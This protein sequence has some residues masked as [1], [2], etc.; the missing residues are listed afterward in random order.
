LWIAAMGCWLL[1]HADAA[2]TREQVPTTIFVERLSAVLFVLINAASTWLSHK[3]AWGF[4]VLKKALYL[5][6]L[7][8]VLV[9]LFYVAT[10]VG[11][12]FL[13]GHLPTVLLLVSIACVLLFRQTTARPHNGVSA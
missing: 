5:M 6:G 9:V 4:A 8:G 7:R 12:I 2:I 11:K 13:F 3:R 1:T 10:S